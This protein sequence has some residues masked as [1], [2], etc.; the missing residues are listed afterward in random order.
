MFENRRLT[1][2]THLLIETFGQPTVY[3]DNWAL[4]DIATEN[5]LCSRFVS[6]LTSKS[7]T[8]RISSSNIVELLK[9]TDSAQIEQIL[10]LIDAVDTGFINS[11]FE[12]VI[13]R[14]NQLLI[15]AGDR[16]NPSQEF[17]VLHDSLAALNW[18]EAWSVSDVVRG[19]L[20]SSDNRVFVQSY[21]SFAD[22]MKAFFS[23]QLADPG[24]VKKSLARSPSGR[25]G[26]PKYCTATRELVAHSFDFIVQNKGM[27]M[28]G[29]EWHDVYHT[30]VPVAYCDIV[31]LDGR[32]ADF[33][34]QSGL[35][36]PAI[37]AVFTKRSLDAG[38]DAIEGWG[39][40]VKL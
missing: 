18:P 31:F 11:N 39:P 5:T 28:P 21:D 35:K 10:H 6:S 9:Q 37:A 38:M 20:A 24:Y 26:N 29:K 34:S 4:N 16:Q 1:D 25:R 3:L 19:I 23:A 13:Q 2:G 40:S 33:V 14:E 27:N 30:I 15:G 7:G 22:K 8:L 32:W 12:D 36:P 17:A